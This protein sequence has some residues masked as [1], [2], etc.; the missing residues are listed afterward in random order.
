MARNRLYGNST[1][2]L[3]EEMRHL[4]HVHLNLYTFLI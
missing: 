4:S 2:P 3:E 1:R